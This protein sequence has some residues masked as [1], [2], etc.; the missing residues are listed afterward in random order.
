[1]FPAPP[2]SELIPILADRFGCF[3]MAHVPTPIDFTPILA[4]R[5]G[6]LKMLPA[7]PNNH[8]TPILADRLVACFSMASAAPNNDFH[9]NSG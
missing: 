5:V 4:G 3:S 1:M 7:L 2:N 9:A 6:R 8:F